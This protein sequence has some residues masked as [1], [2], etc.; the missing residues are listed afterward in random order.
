MYFRLLTS[1]N[2]KSIHAFGKDA[3]MLK[4]GEECSELSQAVLKYLYKDWTGWESEEEKQLAKQSIIE[5]IADVII[6][7][8]NLLE[9]LQ[10]NKFDVNNAI[11]K[12]QTRQKHRADEML[13]KRGQDVQSQQ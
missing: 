10:I 1:I 13:Q 5:E 3:T 7:V 2:R 12:K 6:C 4:A 11:A 8:V 9:I